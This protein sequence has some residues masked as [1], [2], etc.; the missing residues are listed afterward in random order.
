MQH[1]IVTFQDP[2][3]D[4]SIKINFEYDDVKQMVDYKVECTP[5]MEQ[6]IDYGFNL[7]LASY[8]LN[9][10]KDQSKSENIKSDTVAEEKPKKRP[11]KK[12]IDNETK[13]S[14]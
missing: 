6:G 14:D 13:Q 5:E 11:R 9:G 1:S 10:L 3:N 4:R 2:D 12:K 7:F 8:L